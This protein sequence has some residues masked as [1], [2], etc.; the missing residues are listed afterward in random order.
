LLD[1]LSL[2]YASLVD[3]DAQQGARALR[4]MLALYCPADDAAALRQIEGLRSVSS[5]P[6]VRRLPSPGPI[7][8]GR[9]LA[10]TLHF[11]DAAFEGASAFLLGAVLAQFMRQYVSIN[12]FA[13]T[14]VATL[15][16]GSIMRWPE[17]SGRCPTL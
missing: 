12:S 6:V 10:V 9:G 16:R 15:A 14:V 1:H 17:R 7:V 2:N 13:E 3:N 11:D 4:E 5:E 8:F